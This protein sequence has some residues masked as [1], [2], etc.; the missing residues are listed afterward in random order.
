MNTYIIDTKISMNQILLGTT[1]DAFFLVTGEIRTGFTHTLDGRLNVAYFDEAPGHQFARW[2][3]AKPYVLSLIKGKRTP[4]AMHLIF[5]LNEEMISSV[6][7]NPEL[8]GLYL[9]LHFKENVLT[10]TTGTAYKTFSLDKS[11]D[12]LFAEYVEAF[13]LEKGI[14]Y[15]KL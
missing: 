6:S 3:E 5:A 9:N 14:P 10:L 11:T 12:I 13:L 7:T 4:L 15:E 1:F 2:E 8:E